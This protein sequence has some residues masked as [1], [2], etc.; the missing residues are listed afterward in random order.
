MGF[1]LVFLD[2]P[3]AAIWGG[4]SFPGF[5]GGAGAC[6]LAV[7][8]QGAAC[9][10]VQVQASLFGESGEPAGVGLIGIA[11]RGTVSRSRIG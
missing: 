8:V 11:P 6:A 7:Q 4:E 9:S 1:L 10:G 2:S 5:L 3:G